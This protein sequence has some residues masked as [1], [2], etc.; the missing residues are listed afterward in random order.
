[1]HS[2]RHVMS[3]FTPPLVA[4]I[5]A[6]AYYETF[7]QLLAFID[8]PKEPRTWSAIDWIVQVGPLSGFAFLAGAALYSPTSNSPRRLWR[9]LGSNTFAVAV[10]PWFG[11]LC[12]G[13]VI[14]LAR[15]FELAWLQVVGQPL[16]IPRV[17]IPDPWSWIL[18]VAFYVLTLIGAWVWFAWA[19]LRRAAI[20]KRLRPALRS[21]LVACGMFLGSL[22]GVYWAVT[23]WF[24]AYFFDKRLP[25]LLFVCGI[26]VLVAGM[27]GCGTP[28]S[29]GELRR[30]GLF[31]AM[32]L[33]WVVGLVIF[34]RWWSR[35]RQSG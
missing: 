28:E 22:F 3:W 11:F 18:V 35:P 10:A 21:G 6:R 27:S 17:A 20:A 32:L 29:V 8:H 15:G 16:S 24:R 34:W 4:V 30:R 19:M 1:M 26:L 25:S 33:A 12:Y 14:A 9:W 7:A 23:E 2:I 5:L 31:E 13:V